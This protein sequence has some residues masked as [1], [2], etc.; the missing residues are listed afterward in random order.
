MTFPGIGPLYQLPFWLQKIRAILVNLCKIMCA[1]VHFHETIDTKQWMTTLIARMQCNTFH[2]C[3]GTWYH[4]KKGCII[5]RRFILNIRHVT[6]NRPRVWGSMIA[7]ALKWQKKQTPC[8]VF[9]ELFYNQTVFQKSKHSFF[10]TMWLS[11]CDIF[12]ISA[13]PP[14]DAF[15]HIC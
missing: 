6:Q 15:Q 3:F 9:A 8:Y 11:I 2:Y 13:L 14:E 4:R 7:I 10:L 12:S 5:S 1:Q